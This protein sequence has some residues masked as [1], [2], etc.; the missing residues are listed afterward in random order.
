MLF[1]PSQ[2][3]SDGKWKILEITTLEGISVMDIRIIF[4][5]KNVLYLRLYHSRQYFQKLVP[6]L[7]EPQ[8]VLGRKGPLEVI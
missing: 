3:I 8:K 2:S 5:E 4:V 7:I 1:V 6:R